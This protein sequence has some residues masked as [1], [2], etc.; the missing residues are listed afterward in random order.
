MKISLLRDAFLKKIN[1]ASKFTSSRL[2]SST[3]LQGVYMICEENVINFYSTNLNY[4]YHTSLRLKENAK[5]KLLVEPKKISEFLSL[6]NTEKI[7]V[8]IKEKLFIIES[9]KTKAEFPLYE[10][11]EFP[12]PPRVTGKKQKIKTSFLRENIPFLLFS[13]S[14]DDTRPVLTGINFVVEDDALKLVST[15][16]F[17]LSLLNLKKEIEIPSMI[18]P[19][20]FLM[21]AMRLFDEDEVTMSHSPEEK[22]LVFSSDEHDLYTRLIEGDYPPFER[23]IPSSKKTTVELDRE[24]FLRNVKL[25]SI[26]ARDQS[27]V[28]VLKAEK[29]GVYLSPKTGESQGNIMYQEAKVEG[30]IQRI[31]F[32]FKFLLDLLSNSRSKKVII[33]LL[34][35]DAPALFRLEG[36]NNFIHIIMPV[37][38]QEQ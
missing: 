22:A 12:F 33:E 38:I 27:S 36:V 35:G 20:N 34:R 13:S 37:R 15:D 17:R 19:A 16:G 30:E 23:V 28:V 4:F 32:N 1:N 10:S 31:A 7:E 5:F 21:E 18:V 3:M 6:I 14:A 2:S 29:D 26:F 8:E 25:A 24:E 9:G 11:T